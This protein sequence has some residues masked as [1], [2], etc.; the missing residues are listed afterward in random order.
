MH[1]L[2]FRLCKSIQNGGKYRDET[3]LSAKEET[4][5]QRAR[6]PQENVHKERQ[7]RDQEKKTQGQKEDFCLTYDAEKDSTEKE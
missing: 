4:E 7:E 6:L 5:I 1:I 3:D 2:Q